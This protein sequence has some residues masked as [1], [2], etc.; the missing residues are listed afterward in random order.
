MIITVTGV[1]IVEMNLNL[2]DDLEIIGNDLTFVKV[3]LMLNMDKCFI[4][5]ILAAR[6]CNLLSLKC[7]GIA[8]S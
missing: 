4:V 6:A 7:S 5:G 2:L 8:L 3:L 1:P